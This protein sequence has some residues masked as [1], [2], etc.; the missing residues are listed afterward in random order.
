MSER[1]R[2]RRKELIQIVYESI[3][4][5]TT[6]PAEDMIAMGEALVEVGKT[7]DGVSTADAR[8][9][10]RAVGE[11]YGYKLGDEDGR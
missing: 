11:L 8:A 5:N 3:E 4:K 1:N 10:M 7:L 9:V 6:S 2:V